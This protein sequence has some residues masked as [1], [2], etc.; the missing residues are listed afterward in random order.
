MKTTILLISVICLLFANTYSQNKITITPPPPV[1]K[2]SNSV[3]PGV[4][5]TYIV[6]IPLK[7]CDLIHLA[8]N[9]SVNGFFT[10][11]PPYNNNGYDFI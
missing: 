4:R 5:Y 3:Y 9:I 7:N 6:S 11:S 2:L 10:L 1:Q 8:G